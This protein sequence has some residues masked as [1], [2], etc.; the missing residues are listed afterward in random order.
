MNNNQKNS[1]GKTSVV[2]GAIS[3]FILPFI[4]GVIAII[5]GILGISKQDETSSEKDTSSIIGIVLGV[6]SILYSFYATG[7]I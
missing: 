3:C 2:C 4:F 1:Y 7:Q 6:I 5:F